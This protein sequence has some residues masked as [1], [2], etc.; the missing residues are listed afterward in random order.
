MTKH[1]TI[2]LAAIACLSLVGCKPT[3]TYS[4]LLAD[5]KK[6]INDYIE[7]EGINIVDEIPETW[8]E[9]DYYAIPGY[10]NLYIHFIEQNPSATEVKAGDI[11][12]L[13]YKKYGL[14]AYSDTTRYWTT[15]DGGFPI[16]F[17]MGNMSDPYYCAGWTLAIQTMKYSGGHCRLIC[18]SKQGF[19]EDN[20]SV[21]PR[22]Y[23]LKF[24]IK[25]F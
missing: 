2:L 17:Q 23:E 14:T 9:K 11:I 21:T 10:D 20:S 19:T 15:D 25:P 22:G 8:G 24:T 7:R 5:E 18:P 1:L 6:V 4:K 12:L 3:N 13:R 16:S